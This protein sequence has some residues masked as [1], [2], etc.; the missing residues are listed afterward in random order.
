MKKKQ[1]RIVW[2][3]L[4]GDHSDSLLQKLTSFYEEGDETFKNF[5]GF[6]KEEAKESLV[7]LF[8][9]VKPTE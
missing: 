4:R 2:E 5:Y 7:A 3:L 6:S 8:D 1:K 9:S